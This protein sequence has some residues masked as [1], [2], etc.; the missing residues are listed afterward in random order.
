MKRFPRKPRDHDGGG[1]KDKSK[2]SPQKRPKLSKADVAV[3][4]NGTHATSPLHKTEKTDSDLDLGETD[5]EHLKFNISSPEA[6]MYSVLDSAVPQLFNYDSTDSLHEKGLGSPAKA[7]GRSR[8]DLSRTASNPNLLKAVSSSL[9]GLVKAGSSGSLVVQ[10]AGGCGGALKRSGPEVH[11]TDQ[12]KKQRIEYVLSNVTARKPVGSYPMASP[13]Q[14]PHSVS[15]QSSSM[16]NSP[17]SIAVMDM[18][19]YNSQNTTPYAT[20]LTTPAQTPVQSPLPSPLHAHPSPFHHPAPHHYPSHM[21]Q[22]SPPGGG[23]SSQ[24][25]GTFIAPSPPTSSLSTMSAIS[26]P[27]F[28]QHTNNLLLPGQHSTGTIFLNSPSQMPFR[29][30]PVGHAPLL[31]LVQFTPFSQDRHRGPTIMPS[32]KSPFAIIP[33]PSINKAQPDSPPQVQ[34]LLLDRSPQFL[35][36]R[37]SVLN[38]VLRSVLNRSKYGAFSDTDVLCIIVVITNQCFTRLCPAVHLL[39]VGLKASLV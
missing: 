28:T 38:C 36:Y 16:V 29:V 23:P 11:S 14:Q 35:M 2:S 12:T 4:T 26:L 3:T 18:S 30:V 31:P 20:P 24:S 21:E 5:L 1:K 37:E 19:A 33:I 10:T 17:E 8:E 39:I 34:W 25:L 27:G 22:R 6:F 9:P 7:L 15:S 32:G 13:P